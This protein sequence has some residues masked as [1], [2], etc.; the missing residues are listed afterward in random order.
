M[1]SCTISSQLSVSLL[2]NQART[3]HGAPANRQAYL[4]LVS[5]LIGRA[6]P[7]LLARL[8]SLGATAEDTFAWP[9]LSTALSQVFAHRSNI[10]CPRD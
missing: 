6:S 2:A 8:L 3:W 4:G 9:L 1:N 5:A 7:R 10:C